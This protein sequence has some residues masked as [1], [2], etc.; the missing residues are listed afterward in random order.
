MRLPAMFTPSIHP[1][2]CLKSHFSEAAN[3]FRRAA[4]SKYYSDTAKNWN[5]INE[6]L[7]RTKKFKELI[8]IEAQKLD[9]PIVADLGSAGGLLTSQLTDIAETIYC[10][11]NAPGMV[12]SVNKSKV[13]EAKIGDVT[14]SH[15]P[16]NEIDY[17]IATRVVE[18]LFWPDHLADEIKRIGKLGATYF[19]TFPAARRIPPD[20]GEFPPDRIRRYFAAEEVLEWARQIGPGRLIGIPQSEEAEAGYQVNPLKNEVHNWIYIGAINN[21]RPSNSSVRM[22]SIP[23]PAF[24][25]N[26]R[27]HQMDA[28]IKSLG[29]YVPRPVR[30]IIKMLPYFNKL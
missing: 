9:K 23:L 1:L 29:R 22:K 6:G 2:D 20:G 10:V 13:I 14:D 27:N 17:V 11:D 4:L 28:Y 30:K 3:L 5:E 8:R 21:K 24:A 26:F 18:Y 12:E 16:N 25:F 19:L 15:L 7:Y